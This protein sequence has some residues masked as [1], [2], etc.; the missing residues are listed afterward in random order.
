[1]RLEELRES[2]AWEEGRFGP[3]YEEFLSLESESTSTIVW[4]LW[5]GTTWFGEN[6]IAC[7]GC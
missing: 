3:L 2:L 6:W 5:A 7:W 1:M 4:T